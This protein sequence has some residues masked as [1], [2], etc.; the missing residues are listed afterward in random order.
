MDA[1]KVTAEA[2]ARSDTPGSRL[3]GLTTDKAA[4]VIVLAA[5]AVLAVING[6]FASVIPR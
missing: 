3:G 1:L 4:A 6:S 2:G 5:L